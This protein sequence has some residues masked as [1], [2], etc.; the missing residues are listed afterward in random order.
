MEYKPV[1][2]EKKEKKEIEPVKKASFD[3]GDDIDAQALPVIPTK[4]VPSLVKQPSQKEKKTQKFGNHHHDIRN[5][6]K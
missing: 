3:M 2:K 1:P 6:R 5:M 4:K